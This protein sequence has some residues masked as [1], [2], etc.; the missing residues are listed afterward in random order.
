M[1]SY[2]KRKWLEL[3]DSKIAINVR[4]VKFFIGQKSFQYW[5]QSSGWKSYIHI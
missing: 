2:N 4:K 3:L 1:M 5:N